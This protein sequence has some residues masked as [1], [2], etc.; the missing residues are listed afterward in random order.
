MSREEDEIMKMDVGD[1]EGARKE[2]EVTMD[3]VRP[4]CSN[5]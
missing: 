1:D 4:C 3:I 5:T 2:D